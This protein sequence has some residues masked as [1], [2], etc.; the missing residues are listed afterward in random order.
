MD[1]FEV[2][3]QLLIDIP[4]PQIQPGQP[5]PRPATPTPEQERRA[6]TVQVAKSPLSRRSARWVPR[7]K[8]IFLSERVAPELVWLAEVESAF[9]PEAQSPVGAAGLYQL[10]PATAQ[11]LGLKLAPQDERKNGDKNARAAAAYLRYLYLKFRDWRLTLAA[12][13]AG[14][15]RVR[16]AL[17][18]TQGKTFEDIVRWLPAE[19]QMYVPKFEAVLK[20]QERKTLD[21]LPAARP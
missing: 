5:K 14:E 2:A 11:S 8:P 12:F 16:E 6:W 1:Y 19:T 3:D 10:M 9:N 15:T 18:S 7:L 21:Q 13:N 4:P 17:K 20:R